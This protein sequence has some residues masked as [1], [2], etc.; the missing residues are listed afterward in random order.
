MK[1]YKP[2]SVGVSTKLSANSFFYPIQYRKDLDLWF[3][4]YKY[5]GPNWKENRIEWRRGS[6]RGY[7]ILDKVKAHKLKVVS[8]IKISEAHIDRI[9]ERMQIVK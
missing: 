1:E 7:Y 9:I 6:L 5:N 3:G 4:I 2:W 8:K